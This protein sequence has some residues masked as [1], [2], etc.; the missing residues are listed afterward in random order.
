MD[1]V[2]LS[3]C[4]FIILHNRNLLYVIILILIRVFFLNGVVKAVK[5]VSYLVSESCTVYIIY[6]TLTED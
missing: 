2:Q 4:I 5:V 6:N 1:K 3:L